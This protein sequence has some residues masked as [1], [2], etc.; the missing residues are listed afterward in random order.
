MK[1]SDKQSFENQLT[2]LQTIVEQLEK[3]DVPLEEALKQFQSGIELSKQ[4][5]STLD[6]AEKTLTKL[7]DD[8]CNEV[9]FDN[10]QEDE[11]H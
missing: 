8:D 2:Q 4:L 9:P 1:M 10:K 3:G 7:M 11:N 5:Q 6:N